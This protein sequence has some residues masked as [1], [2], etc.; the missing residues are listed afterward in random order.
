MQTVREF[1]DLRAEIASYECTC[2]Q[3][4][5]LFSCQIIR[6]I[7]RLSSTYEGKD[8]FFRNYIYTAILPNLDMIE[9]F[10]FDLE[11]Q[12]DVIEFKFRSLKYH[13]QFVIDSCIYAIMM[14]YK[15]MPHA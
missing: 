15:K 14:N 3:D 9:R 13:F 6:S 5:R 8:E 11:T 4:L 12:E 10:I 7:R 2:F 1:R